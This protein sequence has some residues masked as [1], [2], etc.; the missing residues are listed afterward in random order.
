MILRKTTLQAEHRQQEVTLESSALAIR[1]FDINA[2]PIRTKKGEV[3]GAVVVFHDI[4]RIKHLE[5]VRQEFVANVS[6]E[7]RTPLA[8]FRGYLE[9]L[10][11]HPDLPRP[12]SQRIPVTMRG[13]SKRANA[14][15][16]DLLILTRIEARQVETETSAIR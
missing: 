1:H 13:H 15:V 9:T 4:T 2:V 14:L 6:H 8:I 3:G 16:E 5:G 10:A 7:L 12:E 11:D